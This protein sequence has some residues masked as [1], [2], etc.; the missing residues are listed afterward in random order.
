VI[1]ALDAVT[2]LNANAVPITN[3]LIINRSF[4]GLA[5]WLAPS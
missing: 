4:F 5:G 1:A 2:K 3:V